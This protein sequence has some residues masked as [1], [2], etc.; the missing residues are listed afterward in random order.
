MKYGKNLSHVIELSDPEWGPSW[1]NYKFMKKKI[2]EIVE[3]STQIALLK[4]DL[5]F[6][7]TLQSRREIVEQLELYSKTQ[8]RRAEALLYGSRKNII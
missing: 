1:I 4:A 8:F 3:I 7:H 6:K 5:I 2:K